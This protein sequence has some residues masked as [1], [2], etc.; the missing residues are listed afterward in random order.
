MSCLVT[1]DFGTVTIGLTILALPKPA[2]LAIPPLPLARRFSLPFI[3]GYF[4]TR[5]IRVVTKDEPLEDTPPPPPPL[6][7]G[8]LTP[9]SSAPLESA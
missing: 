6:H 8:I 1:L 3:P 5:G 9:W 7:L 2:L 4:G